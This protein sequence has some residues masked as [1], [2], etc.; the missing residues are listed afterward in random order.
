MQEFT[1]T[2]GA[3]VRSYATFRFEA[4]SMKAT[5]AVAIAKYKRDDDDIMFDETDWNNV[6]LPSIVSIER[7]RDDK[8][9][10]EGHDFALNEDDARDLH[11]QELLNIVR[12]VAAS[13]NDADGLKERAANVLA[14]IKAAHGADPAK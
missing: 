1:A 10:I 5:P 11:A 7:V 12:L 14:E 8:L 13:D 6:A 2:I 3:Y 9:V 4:K